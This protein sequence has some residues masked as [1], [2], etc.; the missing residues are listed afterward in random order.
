MLR[1]S[2]L[3][4]LPLSLALGCGGAAAPPPATPPA[5]A[6]ASDATRGLQLLPDTKP[7]PEKP[8]DNRK[9]DAASG[10]PLAP[11]RAVATDAPIVTQITEDDILALVNKNA[12]AF[13]RCQRLGAGASKSW[14]ATVTIKAT[15]SPLGTVTAIEVASSTTRSPKVDACVTDAFKKLTFARPAGSGATVFTFPMHFD[16]MQ[17]VP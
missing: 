7:A 4:L 14:R 2:A 17:P 12:E 9:E 6:P 1:R 5:E 11:G 3:V 16:P 10:G 8:A 13:Y 15:V